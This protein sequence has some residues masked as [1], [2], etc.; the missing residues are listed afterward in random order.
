MMSYRYTFQQ[1]NNAV[2]KLASGH[3]A[4]EERVRLAY[5]L[6]IQYIRP[7][8]IED[9]NLRRELEKL[10]IEL[11]KADYDTEGARAFAKQIVDVYTDVCQRT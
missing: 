9:G 5:V 3:E 4:L 1:L 8:D 6:A 11:Q 7:V 10:Q 2:N